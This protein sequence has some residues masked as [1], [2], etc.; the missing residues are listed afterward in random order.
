MAATQ[1]Y[2][3]ERWSKVLGV[4]HGFAAFAVAAILYPHGPGLV[5]EVT[6]VRGTLLVH[7][8]HAT[9]GARPKHN[10]ALSLNFLGAFC[11]SVMLMLE[12][13]L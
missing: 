11:A 5:S 8:H 12:E 9:I 2:T 10:S 3:S 4:W 6:A 7:R 1:G 13:S